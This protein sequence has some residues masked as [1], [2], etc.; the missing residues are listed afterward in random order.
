MIIGLGLLIL[1]II[2]IAFGSKTEEAS[3]LYYGE[4]DSENYASNTHSED[5]DTQDEAAISIDLKAKAAKSSAEDTPPKKTAKNDGGTDAAKLA[6]Q[7][8][9]DIAL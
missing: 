3:V 5:A 6:R 4:E 2:F 8:Y 9:D 1:A 7:I